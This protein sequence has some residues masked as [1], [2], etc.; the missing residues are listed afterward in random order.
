MIRYS[1]KGQY[2]HIFVSV[3]HPEN[4]TMCCQIQ[5][6]LSQ[7]DAPKQIRALAYGNLM[8]HLNSNKHWKCVKFIDETG[9]EY[10]VAG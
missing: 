10:S 8:R 9:K 7:T 6:Y 3:K 4:C 5:D 1:N 2:K